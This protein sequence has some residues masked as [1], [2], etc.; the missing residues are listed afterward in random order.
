MAEGARDKLGNPIGSS[1]VQKFLED[2]LHEEVRVTVL[3]HVQRGGSPS[4]FDRNLGTMM[5]YQAVD[6]VLAARPD[7]EPQMIAIRGNRISTAPLMQCVE[8]T[9]AVAKAIEDHD[10]ERAMDLRGSSFK[11][12]YRTLRTLLRSLP[13][14]PTPGQKQPAL[15]RDELRRTGPRHEYRRAR[16]GAH[17]AGSRPYHAGHR[18]RLQGVDRRSESRR[19]IG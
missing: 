8:Q 15:S 7:D 17:R 4:A 6:T 14:A 1:Y 18:Q 9:R 2:A 16:G 5:G 3:G 12:T 13:H 19:W 10:Y 11:E